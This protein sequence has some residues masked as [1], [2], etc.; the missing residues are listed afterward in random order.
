MINSKLVAGIFLASISLSVHAQTP[1]S[2]K[3]GTDYGKARQTLIDSGWDPVHQTEST[4]FFGESVRRK[5]RE[6]KD[7]AGSGQA[8]CL[9]VFRYRDGSLWNVRTVGEEPKYAGISPQ[10][11]VAKT[12]PLETNREYRCDLTAT[13][14]YANGN[15]QRSNQASSNAQPVYHSF[16]GKVLQAYYKESNAPT[17]AY[18][19]AKF[20]SSQQ[21]T[22]SGRTFEVIKFE[23]TGGTTSKIEFFKE[24]TQGAS[25]RLNL[26]Y[27]FSD[28]N[29]ASFGEFLSVCR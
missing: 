1:P 24:T 22:Q 11:S 26:V 18:D 14:F 2:I 7:C 8:P 29:F 27:R 17:V 28:T 5:Y 4:G 12:Y 21:V 15:L 19:G 13:R 3:E 23:K 9:F 6:L 16:D 20:V 25:V 10:R